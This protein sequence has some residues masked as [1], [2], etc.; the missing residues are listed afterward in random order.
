MRTRRKVNRVRITEDILRRVVSECVSGV[1]LESGVSAVSY[2]DEYYSDA[3]MKKRLDFERCFI[4][5][6]ENYMNGALVRMVC[7]AENGSGVSPDVVF[8]RIVRCFENEELGGM[9][10]NE[11]MMESIEYAYSMWV[12]S[13]S[14]VMFPEDYD[15]Y[16]DK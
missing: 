9:R 1:L 16:V 11:S 2:G 13:L 12:D 14:G 3:N 10:C 6:V 4:R 5:F 7:D 8:K 15:D